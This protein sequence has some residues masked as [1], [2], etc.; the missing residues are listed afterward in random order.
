MYVKTQKTWI[1][2]IKYQ[3]VHKVKTIILIRTLGLGD[4]LKIMLT[5]FLFTGQKFISDEWVQRLGT[6]HVIFL[7]NQLN[8]QAIP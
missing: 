6:W 2:S 7:P 1:I 3:T 5:S 8:A 4:K